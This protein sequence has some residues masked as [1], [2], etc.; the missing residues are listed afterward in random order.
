MTASVGRGEF[1][2]CSRSNAKESRAWRS[3][4]LR[5]APYVALK[6]I[7]RQKR[8]DAPSKI[9]ADA[10]VGSDI[11]DNIAATV[12]GSSRSGTAIAK[13]LKISSTRIGDSTPSCP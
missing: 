9:T 6:V 3:L 7:P 2:S 11:R 12:K 10:P 5:S 1:R 8:S 4:L 13:G